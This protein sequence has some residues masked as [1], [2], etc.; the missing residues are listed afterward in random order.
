MV[1]SYNTKMTSLDDVSKFSVSELSAFLDNELQG[2]VDYPD[3]VASIFE[4]NKITGLMFLT[5]TPEE[6]QELV[7][8]IGE[9]KTVKIVIDS[10]K[11]PTNTATTVQIK[12]FW[13][14][15]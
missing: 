9:R 7:P 3:R 2:K 5:L 4:D 8:L 10:L 15:H 6:L 11:E 13:L 12:M 14:V 1:L